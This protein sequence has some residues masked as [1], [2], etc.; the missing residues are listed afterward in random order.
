MGYSRE[1]HEAALKK[2][3]QRQAKSEALAKQKRSNFFLKY[4]RAREIE[5]EISKTAIRLSKAVLRGA[6]V[7]TQLERLK[8]NNLRLQNELQKILIDAGLP[9]NFLDTN[10]VCNLCKDRGFIDGHRCECL[11]KLL[12]EEAYNRINSL[13]PMKLTSFERFSLNYYPSEPQHEGQT[14]PKKRMTAILN[15]CKSYA[16]NFSPSSK[17]LLMQG[18]TGLGKTYLSL[19]IAKVVIDNGFGVIYASVPNIVSKLEREY[20]KKENSGDFTQ[21]HLISCDLL[22]LDDLGTEFLNKFSNSSI[23]N[24]INSRIMANRS[25]IISTNLNM[26]DLEKVYSDRLVSRFMENYVKLNFLGK[27]IRQ[28]KNKH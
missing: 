4:P 14:P 10:Y 8:Q 1:V 24:I 12:K 28:I 2:L 21:D 25:T 5:Y 26:K 11:N 17:S 23:Y 7:K 18:G 3:N 6:D 22:I 19:A 27:D 15:Y 16:I 20:F 9:T 13:S